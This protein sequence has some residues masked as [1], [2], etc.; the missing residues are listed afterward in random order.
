MYNEKLAVAVKSSGKVLR[1][2][3]DTVYV[4]FG[5]EYSLLI[6]NLNSVRAEVRVTIDN[7]DV[8]EGAGLV[9][10]PKESFELSRFIKNGNL[11]KGNRFKFIERTASI[12]NHR[13]VG[14]EDGLI[15]IEFQFEKSVPNH[16]DLLMEK[17]TDI[18]DALKRKADKSDI[19]YPYRPWYWD[20]HWY[21][22][23]YDRWVCGSP[24]STYG[25]NSSTYGSAGLNNT[26]QAN[27]VSTNS[28][29]R[30]TT[31]GAIP[32]D[33]G[34]TVPGSISEQVFTAIDS[35]P[36][37]STVHVIV[38]KMVG[39]TEEGKVVSKPVLVKTK[40]VCSTCGKRNKATAKFCAECGTSLEIV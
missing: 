40:P 9:V 11:Q 20:R 26:V 28:V 15:R 17:L 18:E 36:L 37:E 13:G 32:N 35:F 14:V 5:T 19:P 30:G 27:A 33:V 12:E 6:K 38:L 24:T 4:P 1:E 25:D 10:N 34:I 22:P 2:F 21:G 8:T 7:Q 31:A 16:N 23:P 29:F 3:K 39:E